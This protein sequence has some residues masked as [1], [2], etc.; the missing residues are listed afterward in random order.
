LVRSQVRLWNLQEQ[1]Q[2][3]LG[4]GQQQQGPS[5]A[6]QP[7]GEIR[8]QQ[9]VLAVAMS[10]EGHVFSAG[11]DNKAMLWQPSPQGGQQQPR[12]IAEV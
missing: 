8:H 4:L 6:A 12:Q 3:A 11:C 10:P 7:V 2:P 1:Q 5:I 9:P